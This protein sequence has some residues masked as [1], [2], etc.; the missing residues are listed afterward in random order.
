MHIR[1]LGILC[2]CLAGSGCS[3]GSGGD[4]DD[5]TG[6]ADRSGDTDAPADDGGGEA[7]D[8]ATGDTDAGGLVFIG[9]HELEIA[10]NIGA[11]DGRARLRWYGGLYLPE[12]SPPVTHASVTGLQ[13][14]D[15][16]DVRIALEPELEGG[17][18][19]ALPGLQELVFAWVDALPEEEAA[20][21]SSGLSLRRGALGPDDTI[22]RVQG[23]SDQ[24]SWESECVMQGN[25]TLW[26]CH[27]GLSAMARGSANT[28]PTGTDGPWA[29]ASAEVAMR[30]PTA[31]ADG[32][33]SVTSFELH[34]EGVADVFAMTPVT[35]TPC[36]W[37]DPP[38]CLSLGYT[39]APIPD[40]LCPDIATGFPVQLYIVYEGTAAGNPFGGAAPANQCMTGTP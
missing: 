9:C 18:L 23:T 22:V 4:D 21:A 37:S 36:T 35:G 7:A 24:G 32:E 30:E 11:T 39:G 5:G 14:V 20:C 26:T 17:P 40:V 3:S 31:V 2:A 13:V 28:W 8:E 16:P 10:C 12:G 19:D 15:G 29:Q 25:A 1:R 27:D 38:T 6:D 34:G 33:V